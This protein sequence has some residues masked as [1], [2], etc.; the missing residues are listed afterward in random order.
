MT[1]GIYPGVGKKGNADVWIGHSTI[2]NGSIGSGLS[3]GRTDGKAHLAGERHP[4]SVKGRLDVMVLLR[5]ERG[6]LRDL[7][8]RADPRRCSMLDAI[9]MMAR[10]MGGTTSDLD[11]E[12]ARQVVDDDEPP[13]PR[14]TWKATQVND[15]TDPYIAV[16]H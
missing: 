10:R 6:R 1:I 8:W 16:A 7:T 15:A 12:H 11:S 14:P 5:P 3:H 2:A 4:C 9:S 13:P